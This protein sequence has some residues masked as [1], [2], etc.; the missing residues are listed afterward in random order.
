MQPTRGNETFQLTILAE[1][2]SYHEVWL[3]I[4]R[5]KQ[6]RKFIQSFGNGYGIDLD[7]R[8]ELNPIFAVNK[9]V[10]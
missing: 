10:Q 6:T 2:R 1:S 4:T 7:P 3:E 9:K 5:S 8:L